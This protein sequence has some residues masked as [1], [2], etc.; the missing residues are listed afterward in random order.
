MWHFSFAS[1]SCIQKTVYSILTG[2]LFLLYVFYL[3][4][5]SNHTS[6]LLGFRFKVVGRMQNQSAPVFFPKE[7][8]IILHEVHNLLVLANTVL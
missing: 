4:K 5:K 1:F 8:G 7:K 6:Y 3:L 2:T